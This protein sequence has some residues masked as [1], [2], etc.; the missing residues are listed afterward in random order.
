MTDKSSPS[1]FKAEMPQIPGV[2]LPSPRSPRR[3]PLLPLVI[4]FVVLLVLVLLGSR[5]LSHSRPAEPVREVPTPQIEIPSPPPD[6]NAA[7]PHADASKPVIA[8]TSDLAQPWSSADFFIRN[9]LT[10]E[11]IPATI[12]RLPGGNPSLPSGYWAFSRNDPYSSCKL[13]YITD[14]EKLRQE[15]DYRAANHPLVGNPCSRTLFDPLRT[16]SL[17]GNTWV[18]GAIVQG[19]EIRPPFGV[20]IKIQGKQILAIRTE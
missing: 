2:N 10:G 15:Y 13:E 14:L 19:S 3:N 9:S 16:G 11:N 20:E 17:P 8:E 7:L 18:R 12:V 5:W 6:P 1:S 4:G